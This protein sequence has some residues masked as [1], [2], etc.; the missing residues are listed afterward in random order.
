MKTLLEVHLF[1]YSFDLYGSRICVEFVS[2]IREEKKF[3]S[4]NALKEQILKDC[5]TARVILLESRITDG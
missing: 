4:F 3:D 5:D 1:D 2:K